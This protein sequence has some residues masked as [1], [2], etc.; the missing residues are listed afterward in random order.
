M[1]PPFRQA[2][3]DKVDVVLAAASIPWLR[4]ETINARAIP[5]ASQPYVDIE[6]PGGNEQPVERHVYQ[7]DGEVTVNFVTPR[8]QSRDLAEQYATAFRIAATSTTHRR[9]D[10]GARGSV[11][12]TNASP[13]SGG[14]N[15]GG[16]WV[17]AVN[18]TYQTFNIG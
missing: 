11:V 1:A 14:H 8:A 17:E 5:D 15:E 13:I 7:E 18:L 4:K 3:R 10:V 16:L 2:F 6:F 9:F 12:V